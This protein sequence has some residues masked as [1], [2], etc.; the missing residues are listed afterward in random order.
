MASTLSQLF[1]VGGDAKVKTKANVPGLAML[2]AGVA[3]S[4]FGL[5]AMVISLFGAWTKRKSDD[6]AD[7]DADTDG[8]TLYEGGEP[9]SEGGDDDGSNDGSSGG[10]ELDGAVYK[11]SSEPVP[12]DGSTTTAAA[13]LAPT[14]GG[15][16][17]A[18]SMVNASI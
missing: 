10:G 16:A 5:V 2:N 8:L 18:Q 7:A 11:S 12:A 3:F 17:G 15:E 13:I 9:S 4:W 1:A 6:G 14:E